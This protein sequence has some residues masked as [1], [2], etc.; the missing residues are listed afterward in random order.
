MKNLYILPFVAT[1]GP[2][3]R[4]LRTG[5][6]YQASMRHLIDGDGTREVWIYVICAAAAGFMVQIE[7]AS[8]RPP[9]FFWILATISAVGVFRIFRIAGN[10]DRPRPESA[11]SKQ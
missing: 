9:W 10:E 2:H 6:R 1:I 7:Y 8:G 5:P 4:E 3:W 11:R